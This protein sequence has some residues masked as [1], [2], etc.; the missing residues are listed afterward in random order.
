M[1]KRACVLFGCC[2]LILLSAC[3]APA[4]DGLSSESAYTFT[5]ALG[6]DVTV[7]NGQRVAAVMGSFA[8]TWLLAGGELAAYTVDALD[9]RGLDIEEDAVNLGMMKSPSVEMMI[10]NDIDFVILSAN[11]AE[12]VELYET[13]N[14]VGIVTA[15]FDVETFEEY[16]DMLDICTN[17]TGRKDFYKIHG[18]DIQAQISEAVAGSQEKEPPKVLFIRSFSTGA[19]AK[20]SDNMTGKMLADLGCVNIA[21]S[22][23]A[24]LEDLS[25]E[26]IIQEDPDFIFV[27]TMGTSDEK[28]LET[29]KNGI[30]SNPAWNGLTAVQ[31]GRYI[32]L[33]KTLFH[34]KPNNR[35]GE[36]YA[37][38]SE[39][40]YGKE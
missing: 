33:P 34:L 2:V 25:M 5:D 10:E 21:D 14:N 40:L 38:L 7:G 23:S 3:G 4:G 37:L 27:V 19:R 22:E 1:F 9:E 17:I 6:H 11:I 32:V 16:L 15:Y 36:G 35:W 20:G 26:I 39:V 30:E 24:L 13:L 31:N 29:L 18:L 8:E 28:A 12:H